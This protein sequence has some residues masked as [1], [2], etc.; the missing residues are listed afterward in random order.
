MPQHVNKDTKKVLTF[1]SFDIVARENASLAV[2]LPFPPGFFVLT[3]H[4]YCSTL[5]G[6]GRQLSTVDFI[7]KLDISVLQQNRIQGD[8]AKCVSFTKLPQ[9]TARLRTVQY[10]GTLP[11]NAHHLWLVETFKPWITKW[12]IHSKFQRSWRKTRHILSRLLKDGENLT[13]GNS[14][15]WSCNRVFLFPGF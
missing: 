8:N 9:R 12:A 6:G 5:L 11:H 7:G 10:R 15:S 2:T 13:W 1:C 14:L 4:Q 3:G